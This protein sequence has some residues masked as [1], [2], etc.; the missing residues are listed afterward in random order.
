MQAGYARRRP[1]PVDH[2]AYRAAL[3]IRQPVDRS[4]CCVRDRSSE[5]KVRR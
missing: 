1:V 2:L 5:E 3:P 4:D